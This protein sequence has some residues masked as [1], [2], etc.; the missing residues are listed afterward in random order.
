MFPTR[1]VL[2]RFFSVT[3]GCVLSP[4]STGVKNERAHQ[5]NSDLDGLNFKSDPIC[6]IQ[7]SAAKRR[8]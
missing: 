7:K 4:G 6:A 1:P 5:R 2:A 3:M 8:A